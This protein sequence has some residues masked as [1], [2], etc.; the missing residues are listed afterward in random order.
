MNHASLFSG[1]GGFDLAAEWAGWT[2]V[3]NCEI[4]KFCQRV[5]KYH[6]PN[7]IQ[8]GD[9]KQ[10]KFKRDERGQLWVRRDGVIADTE[11]TGFGN[12]VRG[13]GGQEWE[14]CNGNKSKMVQQG[15][16]TQNDTSKSGCENPIQ[17]QTWLP[18]PSIDIITGGFPCQP[19]SMAGKRKG[20][21]D[22]RHLWP[23]MLRAIREIKPRWIVGENVFGFTNWNRGMVFDQALSDLENEG[24][25]VQPFIIPACGVNA[26]H[27]RDRVWIVAHSTGEGSGNEMRIES[28]RAQEIQENGGKQ[29]FEFRQ[30]G[31]NGSAA[32]TG[33]IRPEER[34][35]PA[36]GIEQFCQERDAADT[37]ISKRPERRLHPDGRQAERHAGTL[38]ARDYERGTWHNFP[39]EPPLRSRND[40]FSNGLDRYINPEIYATI[41]K[42]YTDKDLQKVWEA[43]QP[44]EV[45]REIGRLYKIHE[46][47]ILLKVLQLCSPANTDPKGTSV[48]CQDASGKT[49]RKLRE[50]GTLANTPQGREL[51][52]QFTEQFGNTL[53]Y[54][55]HE[56]ALVALEAERITGSAYSKL[57]N[58]SIKAAGNAIVPQIAFELF[59]AIQKYE[60]MQSV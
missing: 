51:E 30:G 35:E 36:V 13:Y 3:F 39:T 38:Y 21:D 54:L 24:Y 47:G 59:K 15:R 46:P 20:T 42:R 10:L 6:F 40:E 44:E 12:K 2:N 37:D 27:R 4:D 33:H 25:E 14:S 11:I 48:F 19:F 7:A 60:D 31:E 43:I 18:I 49:M 32:D 23:E 58:E 28:Q 52:K 22:D 56:I 26:P 9:I 8:F 29:E 45:Q 5:L 55:S 16:K 57:R 50:Y 41:S 53:P 34:S 17:E 1:I